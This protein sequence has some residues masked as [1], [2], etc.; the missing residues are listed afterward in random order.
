[1]NIEVKVGL[2]GW[3]R[4]VKR[5][6]TGELV[7]E[8]SFPN[9]IT[10]I[11]LDRWGTDAI[12]SVCRLGGGNTTPAVTDTGLVSPLIANNSTVALGNY[13]TY[14]VSERWTECTRVYRF[15]PGVVVNSIA[16]VGVGWSS[17]LWS[18][19]L[20]KDA[21]GNPTTIQILADEVLDVYY[22]IR[23]QFPASDV[24][25]QIT[26]DGVL[27]DWT[28]RPADI[29]SVPG[30]QDSWF[31]SA[32]GAYG[33]P[34]SASASTGTI[35]AVNSSSAALSTSDVVTVTPYSAGSYKQR[36]ACKF[37]LL[38]ANFTI[39]SVNFR[40]QGTY[41]SETVKWQIGFSNHSTGDGIPKT[42]SQRL[43]LT[44]DFSWGRG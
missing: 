16:E 29:A 26:L 24:T 31:T 11:G 8:L 13:R 1:M 44:F 14:S 18:R 10:N 9:I 6:V 5:K 23:M 21:F 19:A 41:G 3:Y 33:V 37:D 36:L 30:T 22:T 34:G 25:G 12:G 28:L 39:K 27:Y 38:T 17:G 35:A 20:I 43:T 40:V 15:T 7:E 32:F 42:S 2:S 4:F